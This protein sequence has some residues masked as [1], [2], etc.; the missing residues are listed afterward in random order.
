MD[1]GMRFVEG[2]LLKHNLS[3]FKT[4]FEGHSGS[5][6]Y[7]VPVLL[8][9]LLPYTTLMLRSLREAWDRREED[10][11]LFMGL[12]FL[13]VF[14]FFSLSGTKLPHYVIYGYTPLFLAMAVTLKTYRGSWGYV[15]PSILL[16]VLL[17]FLPEIVRMANP[18][19]H[20]LYVRAILEAAPGY[21]GWGYRLFFATAIL[22]LALLA[23]RR[24][25][26]KVTTLVLG[27]T[28]VVAVN[29]FVIPL[30]GNL[31][32]MPVKEAANYVKTHNLR[33]VV[34]YRLN[35]P[36]FIVYSGRFVQK[37]TPHSGDTVLTKVS[38]LKKIEKIG[39]YDV[40]Y[41]KNGIVLLKIGK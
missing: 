16:F 8:V 23:W 7:Y 9:G 14:L 22:F 21:A 3:R 25:E 33:D 1:Q 30:Y 19:V 34:M 13:F 32:Q 39:R 27:F 35:M 18:Y 38:A 40:L 5:L 28:M 20:D 11:W 6:L 10:L 12:W 2:F 26:T 41:E 24:V 4:S 31:A 29:F 15:L 36:S 37:R 17:L